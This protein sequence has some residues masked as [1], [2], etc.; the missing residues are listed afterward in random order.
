MSEVWRIWVLWGRAQTIAALWCL[1]KLSNSERLC[2]YCVALLMLV[3]EELVHERLP[4]VCE[5]FLLFGAFKS[6]LLWLC[7]FSWLRMNFY[8]SLST[9]KVFLLYP[10]CMLHSLKSIKHGWLSSALAPRQLR[11]YYFWVYQVSLTRELTN[12]ERLRDATC[13]PWAMLATLGVVIPELLIAFPKPHGHIDNNF[14]HV[15]DKCSKIQCH[16]LEQEN[17]KL[18]YINGYNRFSIYMCSIVGEFHRTFSISLMRW[19]HWSLNT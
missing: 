6:G 8:L 19:N 13:A 14:L 4:R 2:V 3:F 7:L 10:M 11:P 5:S 12:Y 1:E 15:Y 9:L 18:W 17:F 16:G